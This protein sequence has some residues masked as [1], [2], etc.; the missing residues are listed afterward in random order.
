VLAL[1]GCWSLLKHTPFTQIAIGVLTAVAVTLTIRVLVGDHLPDFIPAEESSR[2]GFLYGM[3]TGYGEEVLFRM[4]LMPL[5]FFGAYELLKARGQKQRVFLSAI[6]VILLTAVLFVLLHELGETDGTIV[7]K[8]VATR[9]IVPGVVMGSLFFLF[10]P[11]FVI[12]MH[13][14]IPL[15]F[16]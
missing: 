15:L 16:N 8:L 5:F 2:P 13:I 10:G 4:L 1:A 3:A 6:A 11:G 12:A 7:W 14:M 9:F